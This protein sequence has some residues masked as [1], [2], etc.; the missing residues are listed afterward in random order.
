MGRTSCARGVRMRRGIASPRCPR[1]SGS[2]A[3]AV[4][5]CASGRAGLG[6]LAPEPEAPG[7]SGS[8]S[9]EMLGPFHSAG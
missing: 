6:G 8:G 2:G 5:L 9:F 1:Q 3:G 7:R 4:G